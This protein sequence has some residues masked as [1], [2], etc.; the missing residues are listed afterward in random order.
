[1][2]ESE[3]EQMKEAAR[4]CS[5]HGLCFSL[6]AAFFVATAPWPLFRFIAMVAAAVGLGIRLV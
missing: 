6:T 5:F 3:Y 2:R 1:V 4:K